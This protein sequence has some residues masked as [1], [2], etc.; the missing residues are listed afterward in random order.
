MQNNETERLARLER[1]VD[2]LLRYLGVDPA[3]VDA[4][5]MPGPAGAGPGGAGL[6]R[7]LEMAPQNEGADF[8]L[9]PVYDALRRGKT[10]DAIKTY[11]ELT[12]A[13]LAEAKF[14]VDSIT[15]EM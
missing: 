2:Y 15:R 5:R 7:G 13:S 4:G 3:D 11:R 1:R 12:G 8:A 14:A 9:A 10:V 6:P